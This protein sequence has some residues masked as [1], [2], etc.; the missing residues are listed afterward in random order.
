MHQC[1]IETCCQ[2][3][4]FFINKYVIFVTKNLDN[5]LKIK[6]QHLKMY[7]REGPHSVQLGELRHLVVSD[8]ASL[9]YLFKKLLPP[10]LAACLPSHS[11]TCSSKQCIFFQTLRAPRS[12]AALE[13][14][15]RLFL[16]PRFSNVHRTSGYY[17]KNRTCRRFITKMS[18]NS[19]DRYIIIARINQNPNRRR[20]K[21][22]IHNN[23][24]ER[25]S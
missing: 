21:K 11:P 1:L 22:K 9:S 14:Y 10:F 5:F 7:T 18:R 4:L 6:K 17:Y 2:F 3:I 24:I 8:H 12:A 15:K 20:Y 13:T 19:I 16:H 23:F 25:T